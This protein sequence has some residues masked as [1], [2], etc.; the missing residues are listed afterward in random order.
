MSTDGIHIEPKP[1]IM[2]AIMDEDY[3]YAFVRAFLDVTHIQQILMV[4]QATAY[5]ELNSGNFP[6]ITLGKQL[7]VAKPLFAKYIIESSYCANE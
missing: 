7:R 6:V 5:N 4:G 3:P 1:F 2:T